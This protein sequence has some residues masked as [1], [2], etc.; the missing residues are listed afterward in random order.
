MARAHIF[1]EA[2]VSLFVS[3]TGLG[4][5]SESLIMCVCVDCP[6]GRTPKPVAAALLSAGA[7]RLGGVVVLSVAQ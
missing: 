2:P 7:I 3:P 5:L 4:L 1:L 6:A